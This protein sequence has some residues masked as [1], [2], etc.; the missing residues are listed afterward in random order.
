MQPICSCVLVCRT[1][2]TV[3]MMSRIQHPC[4]HIRRVGLD[5]LSLGSGRT[6]CKRQ[7]QPPRT[8]Q[9]YHMWSPSYTARSILIQLQGTASVDMLRFPLIGCYIV[10]CVLLCVCVCVCVCVAFLFEGTAEIALQNLIDLTSYTEQKKRWESGVKFSVEQVTTVHLT[11]SLLHHSVL[12]LRAFVY[13]LG[14]LETFYKHLFFFSQSLRFSCSGCKHRPRNYWPPL[15]VSCFLVLIQCHDQD[16]RCHRRCVWSRQRCPRTHSTWRM[17]CVPSLVRA[18]RRLPW[19]WASASLK[20]SGSH[21]DATKLYG[22]LP[23]S[24]CSTN[25]PALPPPPPLPSLHLPPTFPSPST[26]T[27]TTELVRS[28]QSVVCLK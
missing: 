3:Q 13:R 22:V 4:V 11:F 25:S 7:R 18:V 21:S 14:S 16:G 15:P 26:H 20:T 2:P 10:L 17:P 19:E 12:F 5:F 23:V 1:P 9:R 8:T 6:K 27:H 24:H 28:R